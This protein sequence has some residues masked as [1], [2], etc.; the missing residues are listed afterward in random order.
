M[1]NYFEKDKENRTPPR[2]IVG[3]DL[4]ETYSSIAYVNEYGQSE[5]IP[6][7]E[8]DRRTPSVILF[9]DDIITVGEIAKVNARA[10]PDQI[11]EFV[12][13][14]TGKS[15]EEFSREFDGKE[16]SATELSALIL[17]KLKQDAEAYLKTEITDAVI[18]VPAYFKDV[19]RQATRN[20]GE[21][22]GL[23]V[24]QIMNEPAAAALDYGID[25]KRGDQTVF[26]FD[27]GGGSFDVTIVRV[28]GSELKMI[29]TNGDHRLGGKDWEDRI[30]G[31]VT[32]TFEMEHDENPLSDSHAYQEIQLQAISAKEALS[33]RQKV[34]IRCAYNGKS[35]NIELTRE[36]F[37]GLTTDLVKRCSVLCNN[38]LSEANMT[39][40]DIDE[41][42]LVG[43]STRMPMVQEMLT[44]TSGRDINP[45]DANPD[46]AVALGA[47]I[48][49]EKILNAHGPKEGAA[50]NYFD[51]LELTVDQLKNLSDAKILEL[52]EA[53]HIELYKIIRLQAANP[54]TPEKLDLLNEAKAMLIDPQKRAEHI[55]E[56]LGEDDD[57][58][59]RG[60]FI[61][62]EKGLTKT[63]NDGAT[64]SLGYI[65]YDA[66]RG[67][68]SVHVIIPKLTPVP[69]KVVDKF[70]TVED[71]LDSVQIELVQGLEDSEIKGEVT[72]FEE[73][74]L[75][76]C[77]IELP[78]GLP[79]GTSIEVTF[80]Y[81]AD[82]TLDVT[83][84]GP[85]GRTAKVTIE[86][87]TL[88]EEEV[89]D[90]KNTCST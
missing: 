88:T 89:A 42:L 48:F 3:I 36:K 35:S 23:N 6:N 11:V 84:V 22:A 12:K 19:E 26:V 69:C 4:G 9:E 85:D 43:G 2:K 62:T 46:D 67:E 51:V 77:V 7:V 72:D 49:A 74:K 37:E 8:G 80:G 13:R 50:V 79:R 65:V 20:A 31:Y 21:I 56:I 15:K 41:V 52:V 5:I 24:R 57:G 1:K 54:R 70:Q 75:G 44:K 28:S 55:A 90:A 53:K 14:E 82:G 38:V 63:I 45:R 18:T 64:H 60:Q 17:L 73:Y 29:A 40:E 83:A 33:T 71:N 27:L 87:E 59:K 34:R 61:G 81:T 32:D 10:V 58:Y 30:I 86:R 39:W 68:A 25:Q 47:A 16:Y 66:L 76:E 78:P